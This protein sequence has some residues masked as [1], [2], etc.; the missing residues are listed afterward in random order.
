MRLWLSEEI[1]GDYGTTRVISLAY[2]ADVF[3][4]AWIDNIITTNRLKEEK[5]VITYH[6]KR[7][8]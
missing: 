1:T 5:I 7:N 3:L 2:T 8:Q 4:G 6:K